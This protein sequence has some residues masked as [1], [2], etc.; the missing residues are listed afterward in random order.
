MNLSLLSFGLAFPV[1]CDL[2]KIANASLDSSIPW[3]RHTVVDLNPV[4][5]V[6]M[7]TIGEKRFLKRYGHAIGLWQAMEHGAQIYDGSPLQHGWPPSGLGP[8]TGPDDF[9]TQL[10]NKRLLIQR[11]TL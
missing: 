6:E 7:D 8:K 3:L 9:T 1:S 10:Y 5:T 4:E 2:S 11:N